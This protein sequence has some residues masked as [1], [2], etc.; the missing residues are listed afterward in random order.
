VTF[1]FDPQP[2]LENPKFKTNFVRRRYTT[3]VNDYGRT[4]VTASNT[5]CVGVIVP[6]AAGGNSVTVDPATM[7]LSDGITVYTQAELT[8]GNASAG[9]AAD[10]VVWH[11]AEWVVDSV[12]DWTDFGFYQA[13][14]KLRDA[15]GRVAA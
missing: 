13:T 7:R 5:S 10:V 9:V 2:V 3:T 12:G 6:G 15:G 4:T 14:A 8:S 1:R 11:D